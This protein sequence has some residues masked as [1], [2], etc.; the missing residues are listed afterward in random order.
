MIC[1]SRKRAINRNKIKPKHTQ[2]TYDPYNRRQPKKA[3]PQVVIETKRLDAE[4]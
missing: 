4:N 2:K 3:S 1:D